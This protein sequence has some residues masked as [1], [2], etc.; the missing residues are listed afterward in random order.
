MFEL[1]RSVHAEI[2]PASS[3][4][5]TTLQN[6]NPIIHPAVTVCNAGLIQRTGGD[7]L[8]YEEG[9]TDAVGAL[10]EAVDRER[11]AIAEALDVP[12]LR[13]PVIGIEQGYL[14]F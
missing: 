3:I 14:G 11:I 4:W 1:L 5:Q 6:S 10:I 12:V 8:F 9:V 2:A 13:D 7:F